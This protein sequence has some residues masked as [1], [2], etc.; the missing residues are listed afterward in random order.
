MYYDV[1]YVLCSSLF[2]SI[3]H[4]NGDVLSPILFNPYTSDM[5]QLQSPVQVASYSD[6]ITITLTHT[7]TKAPKACIQPYPTTVYTR[8]KT[9]TL[10]LT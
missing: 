2:C 9:G 5:P 3:N 4:S 7:S 6:D 8:T 1:F 10:N